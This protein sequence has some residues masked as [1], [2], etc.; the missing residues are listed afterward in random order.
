MRFKE[1]YLEI[2]I[3]NFLYRNQVLLDTRNIPHIRYIPDLS[4]RQSNKDISM[5]LD[6]IPSIISKVYFYSSVG[7]SKISEPLLFTCHM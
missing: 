6:L 2:L 1:F 4:I 7:I 3:C 5:S